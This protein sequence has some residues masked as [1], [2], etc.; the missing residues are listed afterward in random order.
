MLPN[1][2]A[3]IKYRTILSKIILAFPIL[4]FLI[5][6]FLILAFLVLFASLNP[7]PRLHH[8]VQV[9]V[10]RPL[11][12]NDNRARRHLDMRKLGNTKESA[13]RK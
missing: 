7:H 11:E 1:Q 12:R 2:I 3:A 10:S 13:M 6:A 9:V 4:A 5:L 8:P